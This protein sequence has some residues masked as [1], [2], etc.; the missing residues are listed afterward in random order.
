VG[1]R[2]AN[3]LLVLAAG[4]SDLL[5]LKQTEPRPADAARLGDGASDAGVPACGVTDSALVLCLEFDEPDLATAR[6][7]LDGSP[8]HNNASISD[9]AVTT[10][11]VPITSQALELSTGSTV[12][13]AP[14]TDLEPAQFTVSA[15]LDPATSGPAGVVGGSDY[16]LDVETGTDLVVCT[17]LTATSPPAISAQ[18]IAAEPLGAGQWGFV[19]CTYDGVQLCAYAGGSAAT[20]E[21]PQC[22]PGGPVTASGSGGLDI[23]Q[24]ALGQAAYAGGIDSVRVFT[25]ALSAAE[26]CAEAGLTGC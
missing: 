3:T 26:L 4:C 5:G 25:R 18:S 17:L 14:T 16:E 20:V 1:P 8:A 24:S 10:R 11:T 13:V 9:V 23:G 15:W 21:I 22:N 12:S 6:V 19:A 2:H 7:A